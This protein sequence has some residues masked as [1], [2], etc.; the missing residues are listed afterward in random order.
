MVLTYGLAE[1]QEARVVHLIQAAVAVTDKTTAIFSTWS[2]FFT[3][4]KTSAVL[5]QTTLATKFYMPH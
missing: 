3:F 1:L 4:P 5:V 2:L